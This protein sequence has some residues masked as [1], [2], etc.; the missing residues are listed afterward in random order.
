MFRLQIT[1]SKPYTNFLQ[2][3]LFCINISIT[4][5]LCHMHTHRLFQ[6]IQIH[7]NSFNFINNRAL[8]FMENP[9][10]SSLNTQF[11][12]NSIPLDWHSNTK[13]YFCI[14][15]TSHRFLNLSVNPASLLHRIRIHT[16]STRIINIT[17]THNKFYQISYR[18]LYCLFHTI[19]H[20]SILKF[21]SILA[22]SSHT[23]R[24]KSRHILLFCFL[25]ITKFV[26]IK[27]LL[28]FCICIC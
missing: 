21:R 25:P 9:I 27:L 3:L 18:N 4:H 11:K 28:A 14:I 16:T 26:K 12:R 5:S 23:T 1:V 15:I 19:P 17:G 6:I 7:I 2:I 13:R 10:C 22:L 20:F 24:K 8:F